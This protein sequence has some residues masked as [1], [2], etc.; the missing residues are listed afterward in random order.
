M[1]DPSPIQKA[2]LE[3]WGITVLSEPEDDPQRALGAFLTKLRD[4]VDQL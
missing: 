4:R 1:P 2:I 3:R